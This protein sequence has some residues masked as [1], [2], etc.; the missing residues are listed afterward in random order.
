M[1]WY[2]NLHFIYCTIQKYAQSLYKDTSR[3]FV[4]TGSKQMFYSSIFPDPNILV[5]SCI[6]FGLDK[7]NG[8]TPADVTAPQIITDLGNFTLDFK[9]LGLC[10]SPIFLQTQDLDFQMKCKIYFYLKRWLL[11]T[12]QQSSYLSP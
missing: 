12:E 3:L 2:C 11:T 8:P 1:S 5:D 10:D 6:D 7:T 9:Q 4:K